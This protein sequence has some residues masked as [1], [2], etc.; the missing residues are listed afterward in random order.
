[1]FQLSV[2]NSRNINELRKGGYMKVWI[3]TSEHNDYNQH[4]EVFEGVFAKKPTSAQI[5]KFCGITESGADHVLAGGGDRDTR[6][7]GTS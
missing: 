3:L 7:A 5:Q 2:I 1:M 6:I 4:G